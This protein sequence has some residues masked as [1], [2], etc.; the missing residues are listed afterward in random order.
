MLS[1][2]AADDAYNGEGYLIARSF[3]EYVLFCKKLLE[4]QTYRTKMGFLGRHLA[5]RNYNKL[6][7]SNHMAKLLKNLINDQ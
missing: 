3:D 1:P 7:N 2:N 5:V 4:D 6:H